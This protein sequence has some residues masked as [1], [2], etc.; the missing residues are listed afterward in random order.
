MSTRGTNCQ[1]HRITITSLFRP[2]NKYIR[3]TKDESFSSELHYLSNTPAIA[4]ASCAYDLDQCDEAWLRVSNGER[5]RCG[6]APVSEEQ[7]ERV[8]EE[9]EVSRTYPSN[10]CHRFNPPSLSVA[11]LGQDRDDLKE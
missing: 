4:D 2:K 6:L 5:A 9:L 8:V 11:L 3:I 7:F 1:N 10:E